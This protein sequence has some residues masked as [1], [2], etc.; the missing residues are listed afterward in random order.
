MDDQMIAILIIVGV[1][2]FAFLLRFALNSLVNKGSTAIGNAYRARKNTS[3]P[4][5]ERLADM[6]PEIAAWHRQNGTATAADPALMSAVPAAPAYN[7]YTFNALPVAQQ[8]R[9][10]RVANVLT[11]LVAV[12]G[13][14]V[15]AWLFFEIV[16]SGRFALTNFSGLQP[17]GDYHRML[18]RLSFIFVGV[19]LAAYIVILV[20]RRLAYAGFFPV[21]AV[22][23][24]AVWYLALEKYRKDFKEFQGLL[25]N[26]TL[27]P[28][29]ME[30]AQFYVLLAIIAAAVSLVAFFLYLAKRFRW[31]LWVGLATGAGATVCSFLALTEMMRYGSTYEY[32]PG[33]FFGFA[34]LALVASY[35]FVE[36]EK[37]K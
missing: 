1:V 34:L 3:G 16:K 20:T 22:V 23:H 11:I 9:K 21:M 29:G 25:G 8:K 4:S 30:S 19:S 12:A 36:R 24:A 14:F 35:G 37:S 28:R 31:A 6:Y 5:V 13:I 33:N 7:P 2:V 32:V 26:R 18:T 15:N 17:A 27:V 10:G